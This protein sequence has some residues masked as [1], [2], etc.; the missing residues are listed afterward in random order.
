MTH[1]SADGPMNYMY[2][3]DPLDGTTLMFDFSESINACPFHHNLTTLNKFDD[4]WCEMHQLHPS[5]EAVVNMAQDSP[6]SGIIGITVCD[7][8]MIIDASD[9]QQIDDVVQRVV[10]ALHGA[11]IQEAILLPPVR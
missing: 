10:T 2:S 4:P 9:D 11:G 5:V 6:E 1:V 8:Q 7:Q 3:I